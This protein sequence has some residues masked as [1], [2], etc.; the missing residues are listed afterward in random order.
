MDFKR[1]ETLTFVWFLIKIQLV[2]CF[3][4]FKF[5]PTECIGT[6]E[7]W[8]GL[9]FTGGTYFLVFFQCT[10][11]INLLICVIL[12][13][14]CIFR[15]S[16]D[17]GG[18]N[19]CDLAIRFIT[20]IS[21]LPVHRT[22]ELSSVLLTLFWLSYLI[23]EVLFVLHPCI[24]LFRNRYFFNRNGME[25][26]GFLVFTS[27]FDFHVYLISCFHG[28]GSRTRAFN[29]SV[30]IVEFTILLCYIFI[31]LFGIYNFLE[32]C[33]RIFA[34]LAVIWLFWQLW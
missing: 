10:F 18:S 2:F 28:L 6:S 12:G 26:E 31:I 9:F 29:F 16:L 3:H 1:I 15:S 27:I 34:I 33:I 20:L 21:H 32:I 22:F 7:W 19:D 13:F 8:F 30:K 11:L 4:L 24:L 25:L 23:S 17:A 14:L 5:F